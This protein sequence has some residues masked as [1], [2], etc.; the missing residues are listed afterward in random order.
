MVTTWEWSVINGA[1]GER[2]ERE[3]IT[4]MGRVLIVDDNLDTC[5]FMCAVISKAGHQG[6]FASSVAEALEQMQQQMPDLI[7]ADLMMPDES[8]LDLLRMVRSDPRTCDM[9]FVVLS[10]VSESNYV[11]QAMANG[12]TDYW[13]KTSLRVDDLHSRLAAYLPNG[14]GWAEPPRAHPIGASSPSSSS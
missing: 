14:T 11:D 13:L 12:A 9:P 7:I 6:V 3:G 4:V 2:A 8:G 5:H 10:A 1:P